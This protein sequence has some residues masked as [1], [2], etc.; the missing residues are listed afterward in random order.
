MRIFLG[1]SALM[2]MD[3]NVGCGMSGS[4]ALNGSPVSIHLYVKDVDAT[5]K[6]AVAA[7]TQVTMPVRSVLLE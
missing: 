6:Q 3:E 2:L 5:V 4:K 1:D 7:G